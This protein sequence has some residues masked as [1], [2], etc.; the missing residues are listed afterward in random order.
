MAKLGAWSLL[1][2]LVAAIILTSLA[3]RTNFLSADI[4][5]VIL[6]LLGLIVGFLNLQAEAESL[7]AYA[8]LLVIALLTFNHP[9]TADFS[10]TISHVALY[11]AAVILVIAVK[12]I[13][14][15]E[16]AK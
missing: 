10:T 12:T 2:G 1:I 5:A 7:L 4:L 16:K 11:I 15:S 6:A 13:F 3:E 9:S 8:S 14:V